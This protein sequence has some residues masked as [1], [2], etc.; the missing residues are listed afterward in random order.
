MVQELLKGVSELA[1]A[2]G[3]TEMA[4]AK[5]TYC[6]RDD[7]SAIAPLASC[8]RCTTLAFREGRGKYRM[9]VFA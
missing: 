2:R 3:D 8:L 5:Q 7:S 4:K 1:K 9:L 6:P